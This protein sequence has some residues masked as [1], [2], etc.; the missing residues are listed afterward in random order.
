MRWLNTAVESGAV[1]RTGQTTNTRY[2]LPAAPQ[3]AEQ[4]PV[5]PSNACPACG[6]H[7]H[8]DAVSRDGQMGRRSCAECGTFITFT[9]WHGKP[10]LPV[11]VS[12]N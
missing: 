9:I 10:V 7:E 5:T 8:R 1:I 4:E 2:T 3:Q 6:S 11:A 12:Q